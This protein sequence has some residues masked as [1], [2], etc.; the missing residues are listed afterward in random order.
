MSQNWSIPSFEP[1]FFTQNINL[2]SEFYQKFFQ[3]REV[4]NNGDYLILQVG[5]SLFHFCG[6]CYGKVEDGKPIN[7][8]GN[9]MVENADTCR[10]FILAESSENMSKYSVTDMRNDDWGMRSFNMID[11]N[12]LNLYIGHK[13]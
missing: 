7:V 4:W 12:G 11:P 1:S 10:D 6:G 5:N 8:N 9:F 2:T 3:A 13:I